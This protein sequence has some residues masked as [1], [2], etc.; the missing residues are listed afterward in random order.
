VPQDLTI[1]SF[2]ILRAR[3]MPPVHVEIQPSDDPPV[4]GSDAVFAAVALAAW[5][6]DGLAPEW[7]TRRK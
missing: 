3:D 1:R 4:N 5:R 7:P 6:E 2:G